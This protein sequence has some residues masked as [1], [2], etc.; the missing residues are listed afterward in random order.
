MT[1]AILKSFSGCVARI[2][3]TASGMDSFLTPGRVYFCQEAALPSTFFA[4]AALA[5]A[6]LAGA[7]FSGVF[8]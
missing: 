4:D 7:F 5:G 3:F 1:S 8:F 6:A 2:S